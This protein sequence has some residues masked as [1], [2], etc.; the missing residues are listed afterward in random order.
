MTRDSHS[1]ISCYSVLDT[2]FFFS[3]LG[4][5]LLSVTI[6]RKETPKHG[7]ILNFLQVKISYIAVSTGLNVVVSSFEISFNSLLDPCMIF[8]QSGE[9][10]QA[11]IAFLARTSRG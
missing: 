4:L 11:L 6:R 2:F 7:N 10:P 8:T 1:S 9:R 5:L 3:F